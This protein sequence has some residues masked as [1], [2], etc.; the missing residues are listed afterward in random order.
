MHKLFLHNRNLHLIK[1]WTL[2]I[3]LRTPTHSDIYFWH[4]K[5]VSL[6]KQRIFK[7]RSDKLQYTWT[8]RPFKS[9]NLRCKSIERRVRS[10][11]EEQDRCILYNTNGR[12]SEIRRPKRD[13]DERWWGLTD[14]FDHAV[15]KW[16]YDRS[17]FSLASGIAGCINGDRNYLGDRSPGPPANIFR[18]NEICWPGPGPRRFVRREIYVYPVFSPAMHHFAHVTSN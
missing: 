5:L 7:S 6:K 1:L 2:Q 8:R 14:R 18:D 11:V 10:F 9:R 15:C 16:N 13:T 4:F 17:D 3:M 12:K